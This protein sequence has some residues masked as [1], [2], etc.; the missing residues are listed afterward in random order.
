ML[1][2][3]V[4]GLGIQNTIYKHYATQVCTACTR[5]KTSIQL[6]HKQM[7]FNMIQHVKNAFHIHI[8]YN[9]QVYSR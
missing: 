4:N 8:I 5:S 7:Y 3:N 1:A 2:Y 9:R 6:E